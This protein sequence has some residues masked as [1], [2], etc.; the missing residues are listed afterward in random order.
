MKKI[1]TA[2]VAIAVVVALMAVPLG[3]AAATT[4]DSQQNESAESA[5]N[6]SVNPGEQLAGVVGVQNA[7]LDG[8]MDDRTFGVK[9]ANAQTDDAKAE[10]VS[11]RL[12]EIEERIE[13]HEAELEALDEARE[14]GEITEGE[15]RAQVASLTAEEA[16]TERAAAH[17]NASAG[18]LPE[19]TL[20]ENGVNTEAIQDLQERAGNMSGP[21]TAEIAQ[22]IAGNSVGTSIAEDRAP[23]SPPGAG[24]SDAGADAQPDS[25][26]DEEDEESSNQGGADSD[27]NRG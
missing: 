20:E 6:E 4:G 5:T 24:P 16:N 18:E 19:E 21:E 12:D 9:I 3:A 22:S 23:G 2:L 25:D 8:E 27:E 10:V 13:D 11:E 14:S 15:Y 17:A 1:S 7:E 26:E